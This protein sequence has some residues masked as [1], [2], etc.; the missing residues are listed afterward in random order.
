MVSNILRIRTLFFTTIFA[1][2]FLAFMFGSIGLG[3]GQAFAQDAP[4]A[5]AQ[6]QGGEV[7]K[8]DAPE[9][10]SGFIWVLESSGVIG[11]FILLLS[12]YFIA[13][14]IRLLVELR[15]EVAVPPLI[16][17]Q[18]HSLVEQNDFRGV[19]NVVAADD[20]LFS[21]LAASGLTELPEGVTKAREAMER[22]DDY[23]M[24]EMEKKISMLA[25]LG[26]L[27]PMIGLL[28]TLLGMIESFSVIALSDT[29]LRAS[30]VAGGI[31]RALILTFEGVALSVP[32]IYCHA[33]FRNRVMLISAAALLQAD[34]LMRMIVKAAKS[35]TSGAVPQAQTSA[36]QA[37]T[38]QRQAPPPPPMA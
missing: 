18:C 1:V 15:P 38:S 14:I 11:A 28:G 30:E 13:L 3:G 19:A 7:K 25:V 34:E 8:A 5:D 6:N 37:A 4:K 32:A 17:S 16:L 9:K 35:R 2:A 27:G 20:S 26:T 29:Q 24:A 22:T 10:K 23:K 12:M 31:S 21:T 33:F 36:A